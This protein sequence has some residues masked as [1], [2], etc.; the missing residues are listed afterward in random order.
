MKLPNERH[1]QTSPRPAS[2]Q[3]AGAGFTQSNEDLDVLE[4][5]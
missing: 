2:E 5:P 1:T 4:Q 3:D